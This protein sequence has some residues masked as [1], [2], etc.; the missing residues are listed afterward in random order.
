MMLALLH[1]SCSWYPVVFFAL[2]LVL[3]LRERGRSGLLPLSILLLR[4][5]LHGTRPHGRAWS[6]IP[7]QTHM[8]PLRQIPLHAVIGGASICSKPLDEVLGV[9][10]IAEADE[11]S[12]QSQTPL[13]TMNTTSSLL[14]AVDGIAPVVLVEQRVDRIF[15]ASDRIGVMQGQ[16][17]TLERLHGRDGG[18]LPIPGFPARIPALIPLHAASSF[19]CAETRG[20]YQPGHGRLLPASSRT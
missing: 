5:S 13:L 11:L 7:V 2:P 3:I 14:G 1:G 12:L 4:Y 15:I 20:R 8:P 17:H 18:S 6:F 9:F 19:V 16:A 10:D